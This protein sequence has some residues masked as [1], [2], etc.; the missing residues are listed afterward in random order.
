MSNFLTGEGMF[1][2]PMDGQ[3]NVVPDNF[4]GCVPE[5]QFDG[6]DLGDPLFLL[7]DAG[8]GN[9]NVGAS[10]NTD[11]IDLTHVDKDIYM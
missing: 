11:V 8:L 2:C 10:S 3:R 6:E 1:A 4:E 7:G 9:A 5:I